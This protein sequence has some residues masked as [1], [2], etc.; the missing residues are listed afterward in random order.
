MIEDGGALDRGE[1]PAGWA[2]KRAEDVCAVVQS[3]GTPKADGF[4]DGGGIPFLKVYNIRDQAIDFDYRP[5]YIKKEAHATI[6]RKSKVVPGDVLM[7]IVGPPLGKVAVVPADYAEWNC[8]QALTIFRPSE[9]VTTEWLYHFLRSGIPVSTVLGETRG[10]V[11]QVNISLSQCRNFRVPIPPLPE[12]R[13]IVAKLDRLSARS[14]AARDHLA[15]TAKLAAR[16]KQAI[17]AAAFRGELTTG[18]R[19]AHP[20]LEPAS[21]LVAR[22]PEPEQSRG[23]REATA[24][25]IEGVGAM[26]VN[27][28]GTALPAGWSWVRLRRVARQET[29]H[30]PS[31]SRPEWWGGDV[32]W[33]GIRDAN[34]HHGAVINDT[35]QTT[36][37]DGLANSS[38]RLLPAG[39]VCLSRTAS[40]G[41]VTMMGRPMATSQDFA[42]W[43]CTGALD[44]W[45]LMLGLM[46]EGDDIR[47]FGEGTTHTT[48]Y[49]PEIRA[50]HIK[51]APLEEQREIVRRI[52]SAFARID[53]MTADAVRAAHLLDRLDE[54]LLAKA[55]R[56]ELVPQDPADEPAEAL[57]ARIRAARAEAPLRRRGRART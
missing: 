54:R 9:A 49:F 51:L 35:M 53:R 16:A 52:K 36:N 20:D 7:N 41:Y 48:I 40:V 38:A 24:D 46:S 28:P 42:T 30:T 34:A 12:Q 45:Y 8:N 19:K 57:L 55:F 14:R 15:S 32:P 26:S 13:R 31:R 11:G 47:R 43:T 21:A 5:Q 33:I 44:P 4:T 2:D 29:G 6:G 18:W 50:L 39:T 25:V 17:L 1:I 23:G 37:P 10:V 3:G 27:D 56:G 22:T